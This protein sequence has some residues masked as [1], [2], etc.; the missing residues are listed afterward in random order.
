MTR[1]SFHMDPFSKSN[2]P[3]ESQESLLSFRTALRSNRCV[4]KDLLLFH[5][6]RSD[7]SQ[8][9][10]RHPDYVY[11]RYFSTWDTNCCHIFYYTNLT[12]RSSFDMD[13]FS[14]SNTPL[15][16]QESLLSIRTALRSN[17]YVFKDLCS[18]HENRS[19]FSQDVQGHPDCAYEHY[20][21]TCDTHIC[22]TLT[23]Y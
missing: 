9:A 1:S 15:E 21:C 19:D 14:K 8:D 17:R 5:E 2:T 7:F 23:F 6:N 13:P 12:T 3:L 22:D 20:F 10:Q 11:E 18:S 4:L 16:S